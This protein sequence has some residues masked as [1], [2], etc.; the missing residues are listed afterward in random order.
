MGTS[1]ACTG[2]ILQL[3]NRAQNFLPAT[4]AEHHLDVNFQ[5]SFHLRRDF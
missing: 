4:H 2:K 5:L 1:V 3:P